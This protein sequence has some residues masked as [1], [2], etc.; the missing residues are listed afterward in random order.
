MVD[1]MKI[2]IRN[3]RCFQSVPLVDI[4]PLT[5]LV[6]ENSTGKTSFLSA[7]RFAHE[8]FQRGTNPS[9]NKEPYSL[10]SF[11]EIAHYRRG[12]LG[13]AEEFSFN[14]SVPIQRTK[15]NRLRGSRSVLRES[16]LAEVC[17]VLREVESQPAISSIELSAA[18]YI[19]DLRLSGTAQLSY[20]TPNMKVPKVFSEKLRL[21][22]GYESPN[23]NAVSFILRDIPFL[24]GSDVVRRQENGSQLQDQEV[25]EVSGILRA[26]ERSLAQAIF[27]GAPV[28]TKPARTYDNIEVTPSPEGSHIPYLFARLKAF[29]PDDWKILRENLIEFGTTAGLF[30]DIDVKK[31]S[32]SPSSPFQIAV[33]ISGPS[34]NLMDVGYGVSQALPVVAE[35]LQAHRG[36]LFLLQQPEVH[37]HPRAQA[38]LGTYLA[39]IAKQRRLTIIIETHSDYLIDRVRMDVRDRKGLDPKDVCIL[40]FERHGLDV[41]INQLEIDHKG[42][43][44]GAPSGYRNFFLQEELR[45]L[46]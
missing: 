46:A 21:P 18:D 32:S 22:L 42:N 34:S 40:F 35:T 27:A 8:L 33:N 36:S 1:G 28:R 19:I 31:F 25:N 11:K 37:L 5:L 38:A 15:S 6:G 16:A 24:I 17:I 43:I 39:N 9:F 10:G 30:N 14:L 2:G 23:F 7:L 29:K 20:K 13:R 12:R 41:V 44:L 26:T 4:R 3:F 45:A